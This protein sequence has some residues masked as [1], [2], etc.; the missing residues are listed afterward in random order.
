MVLIG[1]LLWW[2]LRVYSFVLV[3]R[4]ILDWVRAYNRTWRPK[5]A[6]FFA[7]GIVYALTD[8]PL[9]MMR[10]VIPPLRLGPI[11]LDLGTVILFFVIGLLQNLVGVFLL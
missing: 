2:A 3:A 11:A 8:W 5:G 7:A 1:W 10:K 4:I 6:I 9:R